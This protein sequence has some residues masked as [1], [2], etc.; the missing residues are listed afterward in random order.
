[1]KFTP[2]TLI[3]T[4]QLCIIFKDNEWVLQFN[5]QGSFLGSLDGGGYVN[6]GCPNLRFRSRSLREI[7]ER[8]LKGVGN[9]DVSQLRSTW[10]EIGYH[11]DICWVSNGA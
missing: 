11:V 5:R 7:W 6:S 2:E 8:I 10:E 1:M 9:V 4:Y 3:V